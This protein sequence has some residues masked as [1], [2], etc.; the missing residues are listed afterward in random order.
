MVLRCTPLALAAAL[1]GTGA[2]AQAACGVD[3]PAEWAG[4]TE[5][6]SD[7]TSA[8]GAFD[9]QILVAPNAVDATLFTV[10]DTQALR[11]EALP[12][13]NGD[14]VIEL[15]DG[16][17]NLLAE[18]DDGG[19]NLAS[20]IEQMVDPGSYCLVVRS[21][22]GEAMG[23]MVRVGREEHVA[24]TQGS[25]GTSEAAACAPGAPAEI[26]AIETLADLEG[27]GLSATASAEAVAAYR[28]TLPAPSGVT[29]TAV[30][31]DADPAISVFDARGGL[32][33]ENDDADGLNARVDLPEAL[34]AGEYCVGLR[35]VS[36]ASL[37]ITLS[38]AAF[39]LAAATRR[40]YATGEASPPMDGDYP[41][42][43][44]GVISGG[45]SRDMI[46]KA[47]MAWFAF[48]MPEPGLILAE[49]LGLGPVDPRIVLFDAAGRQVGADDDGGNSN[50]ARLAAP[51]QPGGYLVG[52]GRVSDSGFGL[53]RLVLQRYV[54]AE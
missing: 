1:L 50:D 42:T 44:L 26:L 38:V 15:R 11:L 45:L 21:L 51:L 31:E 14:T 35:A 9:R 10:S 19:G 40:L 3:A 7:I 20:R 16:A 54:A 29:I 17:G 34:E 27:R 37:P 8:D 2:F 13:G 18:D 43:D 39:D 52:L 28:F 4:G 12:I 33:G 48:E 36:D 41:I 6:G 22:G 53:M 46:A 5:D 47:E 24:L 23:A 25:S 30:G 49:G 32:L